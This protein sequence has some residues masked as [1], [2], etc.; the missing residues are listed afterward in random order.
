M[1][2]YTHDGNV[3]RCV[4]VCAIISVYTVCSTTRREKG[5]NQIKQQER[6]R[7][8]EQERNER[9]GKWRGL[10]Y[11]WKKIPTKIIFTQG[12]MHMLTNVHK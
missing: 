6:K 12:I 3:S 10:L 11:T 2:Q 1:L 5:Q 7:T 8:I 4:C 9:F